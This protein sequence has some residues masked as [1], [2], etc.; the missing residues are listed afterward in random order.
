MDSFFSAISSG[1]NF[2]SSAEVLGLSLTSWIAVFIVVAG[3][4]FI[5]RGNK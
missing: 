3:L 4:A 2:L 5:I 1:F